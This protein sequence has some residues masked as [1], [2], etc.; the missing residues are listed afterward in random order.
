MT[1]VAAIISSQTMRTIFQVVCIASQSPMY[2]LSGLKKAGSKKK[3][4]GFMGHSAKAAN[5]PSFLEVASSH[6]YFCAKG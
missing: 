5:V 3:V 6:L 1:F 4:T 2:V